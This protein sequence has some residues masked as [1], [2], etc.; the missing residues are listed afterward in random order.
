MDWSYLQH[1]IPFE[2]NFRWRGGQVSRIEA[3]ADAV[4][5]LSVTLLVV[6]AEVPN[7]YGEFIAAMQALPAFALSFVLIVL[8]W[9][10]HFIHFRRY[11]LE[12]GPTTLLNLSLLFVV[13]VYVYPLKFMWAFLTAWVTA[14]GQPA[15]EQ[16]GL[17]P[18][19]VGT[20][21]A[22]YGIGFVAM[23]VLLALMAAQA[24]KRR[25]ELELN[26]VEV[27][28]TRGLVATHLIQAGVGL[29][30]VVLALGLPSPYQGFAGLA[31]FLLPVMHPLHGRRVS[32]Q[33]R[34][35]LAAVVTTKP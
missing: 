27:V 9:Y 12:D 29:A 30:S 18:R 28:L 19:S 3:F 34:D 32:R 2:K 20:L 24:L 16:F 21:L 14:G 1:K 4:F 22:I 15:V 10:F 17:G 11:G 23:Y 6:S 25:Q 5:A 35:A 26:D 8:V 13:L 33:E 31:Y 7:S